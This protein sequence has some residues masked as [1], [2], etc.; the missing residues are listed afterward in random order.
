MLFRAAAAAIGTSH[1]WGERED[2]IK[3]LPNARDVELTLKQLLQIIISH[4][5]KLSECGLA[6]LTS[7]A[8]C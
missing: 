3:L 7:E 2:P 1:C 4:L 5:A 8:L 6:M